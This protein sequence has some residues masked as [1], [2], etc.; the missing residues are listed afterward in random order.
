MIKEIGGE[1]WINKNEPIGNS[2]EMP[3]WLKK[4][5]NVLLTTSGRGSLSL[6]LDQGKPKI[7][8]ALLPSYI[9]D[10]V[11]LPFKQKG[12]ELSYYDVDKYLKP[13]DIDFIKNNN[14]G[15]FLHMGYFGFST[16]DVLTDLI[17]SLKSESVITIEDVT[18]TLFTKQNKPMVSDFAIGSIRKWLG[19]PCGGFIA[20]NEML[21]FELSDANFEFINTRRSS[22]HQKFEYMDSGNKSIKSTYLSGFNKAE[23][24]LNVDFKPYKIDL[25]SEMIIKDLDYKNLQSSRQSNYRF[26][27]KHLRDVDGIEV[28]FNGLQNDTTPLFFPVYVKNN[29]DELRRKLIESDIY[30]PVHWPL[31]RQVSGHLNI[32]TKNIYDSILSIPCDQRYQIEDMRRMINEII[33]FF[34]E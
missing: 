7:K 5:G 13:I 26:L 15:I 19:I 34:E 25:E 21:Q 1:F 29:R 3:S 27:L 20:S 22:L 23:H 2:D 18:H 32:T 17:P 28:I 6:L 24:M 16:N 10:S 8:K 14:A 11:I 33:D 4:F 9:C 12:Y 30:C 31:P